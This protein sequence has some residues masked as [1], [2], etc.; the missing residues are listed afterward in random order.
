MSRE[1]EKFNKIKY[2]E[3]SAKGRRLSKNKIVM[4]LKYQGYRRLI[5]LDP[6]EGEERWK[7][8]LQREYKNMV[9]DIKSPYIRNEY[10][11]EEEKT[12]AENE[13]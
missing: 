6:R 9:R 3:L 7:F 8:L 2:S 10:H 11:L 1:T 12:E 4:T 13:N 5:R